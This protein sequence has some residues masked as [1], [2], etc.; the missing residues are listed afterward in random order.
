MLAA[1]LNSRR[2]GHRIETLRI[3]RVLLAKE[4]PSVRAR[5]PEQHTKAT[6]SLAR[7]K[8]ERWINTPSGKST[9]DLD[10]I[11]CGPR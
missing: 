8:G 2:L 9:V 11:V 10:A 3:E 4:I 5:V 7:N 1:A 6:L